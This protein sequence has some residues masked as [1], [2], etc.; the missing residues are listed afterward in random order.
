[1]TVVWLGGELT[2]WNSK[3]YLLEQCPFLWMLHPTWSEGVVF[4]GFLAEYSL[5]FFLNLFLFGNQTGDLGRLKA[6]LR[7]HLFLVFGT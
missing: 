1:M 2:C 7:A 3:Q 5:F 6:P 4:D